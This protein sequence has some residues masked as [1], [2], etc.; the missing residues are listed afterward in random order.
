MKRSLAALAVGLLALSSAHAEDSQL[1]PTT[2]G[3][4]LGSKHLE[5]AVQAPG[6]R[7]WNDATQGVYA[8][9]ANGLTLGYVPRNSLFQPTTY[10]GWT[11]PELN[12]PLGLPIDLSATLGVATGYDRLVAELAP[13]QAAPAGTRQ[14]VRCNSTAGCRNV[15]VKDTVVPM[16]ALHA[17]GQ[18]AGSLRWRAS[19]LLKTHKD[20]SAALMFST[21]W[22]F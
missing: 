9:W 10:A 20:S 13:G 16:A 5:R 22:R 19:L 1:L 17:G 21:E 4:H 18:I 6:S 15:A 11:T 7:G 12:R 3:V 14:V 2:V 8:I